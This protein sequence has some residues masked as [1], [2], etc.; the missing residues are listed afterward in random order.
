MKYSI[1]DTT[2]TSI[3][4]VLRKYHGNT[5]TVIVEDAVAAPSAVSKTENAIDFTTF[6]GEYGNNQRIYNVV[7]IPGAHTIKVKMAYQTEAR[8]SG[9]LYDYVQVA[10]GNL[11]SMPSGTTMYGGKTLQQVELEFE[12]TDTITFYFYSDSS[13]SNFLGYYAEC[14]GYD[15][16]GLPCTTKQELVE[17]EVLNTYNPL[18][19]AAAI[20]D[21][22]PILEP[23]EANANRTYKPREGVDGFNEVIVNVEGSIPEEGL[24]ITGD[25]S[26]R[27]AYNGWNW[28]LNL[29]SNKLITVDVTKLSNAFYYSHD[30]TTLPFEINCKPSTLI[31]LERT[32]Y[33]CYNLINLPKINN[34]KPNTTSYLFTNCYRLREI[35]E[36]YFNGWDWSNMDSLADWSAA[37]RTHGFNNC[38]SLRKIPMEFLKHGSKGGGPSYSI[39]YSAFTNCYTLDEIIELPCPHINATWTSNAFSNTFSSCYR[40]KNVIFATQENSSP[41][42]VKWKSQTIDLSSIG[43]Y[44]YGSTKVDSNNWSDS[45]RDAAIENSKITSY[46]AGIDASKAIYSDATYAALKDDPDAFC[47]SCGHG[48]DATAAYSRY[49]HDSA[50]ATIN[51]LPDTSAYLATQSS[52]TN[53]IKFKGNSGL[54]TIGGAINTLTEEEIAVAT[55]KGWTVTLV[56]KEFKMKSTE[57]QLVRYDADEGMVFD[58][59]EPHYVEDENENQI[60]EHLYAKTLFIGG[61][62]NILNYIEVEAPA[63]EA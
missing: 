28:Y 25:W 32:F 52:G 36:D 20:D 37:Q 48:Y 13:G 23:L 4:D 40:L 5:K 43:Y 54:R 57:F 39:Y 50:V 24:T 16:Q 42:V 44:P 22:I 15:S 6:Q 56:Q 29:F 9:A 26:Y 55:A 59:A 41:Y 30:L 63:K 3:G 1:E 27:F 2:L 10:A 61:N 58:W 11:T 46:N 8:A 49:D 31:D 17:K 62:D 33:S 18:N 35:P 34:C 60:Q 12:D 7:T 51:S 19:M 45:V 14:Y 21:I 38:Y 47:L 53:T